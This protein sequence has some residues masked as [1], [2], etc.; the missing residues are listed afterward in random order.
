MQILNPK[1]QTSTARLHATLIER[2]LP[3]FVTTFRAVTGLF[4]GG[5]N[6]HFGATPYDVRIDVIDHK[7]AARTIEVC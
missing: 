3:R 4:S 2:P 1:P 6:I 5:M 7:H